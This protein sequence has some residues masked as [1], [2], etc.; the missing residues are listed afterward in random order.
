[1]KLKFNIRRSDCWV[2]FL[3]NFLRREG[4]LGKGGRSKKMSDGI[5][6]KLRIYNLKIRSSSRI[7]MLDIEKVRKW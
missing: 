1:M 6:K 3:G 7:I 4:S 2:N 5:V